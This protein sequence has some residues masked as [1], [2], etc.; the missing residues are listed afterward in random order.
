MSVVTSVLLTMSVVE[1]GFDPDIGDTSRLD[2]VQKWL[3]EHGKAPLGHLTPYMPGGKHPQSETFGGGYNHFP[4]D[5]FREYILNFG[6]VSPENVVLV[7]QP[8][9][10]ETIVVRP[11][12]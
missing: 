10:G 12:Y 11:K 4:I 8:D 7:M 2:E 5:D 6:W 9:H 1:D 3:A